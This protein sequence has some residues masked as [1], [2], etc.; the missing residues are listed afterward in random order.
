MTDEDVT[1]RLTEALEAEEA[2]PQREADPRAVIET[3][4]WDRYA[5]A[6]LPVVRQ[7]GDQRAAEAKAEVWSLAASW[8][9]PSV[10]QLFRD[11]AAAL[12][13]E[14]GR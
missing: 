9:G 6:L 1:A 14:V 10:A 12:R 11:R 13:G 4:N 7:Y 8:V 2:R 3:Q 5:R